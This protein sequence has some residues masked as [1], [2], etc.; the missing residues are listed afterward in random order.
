[1]G[2]CA[3]RE[4]D[5]SAYLDR[6]I[7]PELSSV[8]EEHLQTCQKCKEALNRMQLLSKAVQE[9]PRPSVNPFLATK[10]LGQLQT[11]EIS[12]TPFVRLFESWG[13][14]SL[15]ALGIVL[16][17]FGSSLFGLMYVLIKN[18]TIV[19]N[20]VVNLSWRVPMSPINLALGAI[21][22][23]GGILAFYGFARLYLTMARKELVS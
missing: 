14:L 2:Q 12:E 16:V 7:S 5:L 15:V 4:I 20:L 3:C 18:L 11:E 6:E 23:A 21:F 8:I 19:L 22:M 10:V 9:L 17:P 1:M 13:I